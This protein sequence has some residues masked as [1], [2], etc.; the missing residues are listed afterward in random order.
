MLAK[1]DQLIV[2]QDLVDISLMMQIVYGLDLD[3][4][5]MTRTFCVS[6]VVKSVK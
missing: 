1:Y 3:S 5:K 2:K 6:Y 4:R